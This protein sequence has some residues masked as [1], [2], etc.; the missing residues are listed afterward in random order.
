[1]RYA[2]IKFGRDTF[3]QFAF[4]SKNASQWAQVYYAQQRAKDKSHSVALRALSNKWSKI[5]YTMW[6]TG[7]KYS[8]EYHLRHQSHYLERM[9]QLL[10][11]TPQVTLAYA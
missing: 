11:K 8:E 6:K 9:K 4:C 2:C 5:I 7:T 1:M 3:W 10:T